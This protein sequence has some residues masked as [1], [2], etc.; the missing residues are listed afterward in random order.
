M[1]S[2]GCEDLWIN[3]FPNSNS[4]EKITKGA[5]YRHPNLSNN[6]ICNFI[7]SLANSIKKINDRKGKFMFLGT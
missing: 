1:N 3:I 6:N 4:L 2:T 7:D 5:I